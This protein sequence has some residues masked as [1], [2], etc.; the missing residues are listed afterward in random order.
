MYVFLVS[1]VD[2][3][4][5]RAKLSLGRLRLIWRKIPQVRKAGYEISYAVGSKGIFTVSSWGYRQKLVVLMSFQ[6]ELDAMQLILASISQR[7]KKA[8][9]A[10]AEALAT[11]YIA[12]STRLCPTISTVF[13][14]EAALLAAADRQPGRPAAHILIF[15]SRGDALT[16]EEFAALIGRLRD[17]SVPR[18]LFA[19]GPAD[20]WSPVAR[21]R[22]HRTLSLGRMTLPHELAKAVVAEQIYRAL[23]ILAGHPYH[24]GH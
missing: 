4:N 18:I 3:C 9:S 2:K 17:E 1:T 7:A 6:A 15:D 16:S 8:K 5:F 13:D 24:S 21:S 14:S 22:A 11:D 20:G 23:T 10:A 19:I 12:R